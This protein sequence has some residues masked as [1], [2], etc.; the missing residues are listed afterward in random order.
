MKISL[1]KLVVDRP[2]TDTPISFAIILEI[3]KT[4]I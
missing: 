1:P 2:V 4:A 3:G